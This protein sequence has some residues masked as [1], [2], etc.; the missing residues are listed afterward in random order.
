MR[1]AGARR[2]A[3]YGRLSGGCKIFIDWRLGFRQSSFRHITRVPQ[4]P[5]FDAFAMPAAFLACCCPLH[6]SD[7]GKPSD[8]ETSLQFLSAEL[9]IQQS[10]SWRTALICRD[11]GYS[12]G[13]QPAEP[14][15]ASGSRGSGG[16]V[17]GRGP[18]VFALAGAGRAGPV[19]LLPVGFVQ[20]ILDV[21]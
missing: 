12:A 15:T 11:D 6:L 17:A 1:Y 10:A 8:P 5:T 2:G 7:P 9:G 3:G 19:L 21:A 13:W 18:A 16:C 20:R 4:R 14:K